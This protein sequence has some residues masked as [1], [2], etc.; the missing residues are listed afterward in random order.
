MTLRERST[1]RP[2]AG[3]LTTDRISYLIGAGYEVGFGVSFVLFQAE[4]T[5]SGLVR[6]GL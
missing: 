3:E 2:S 1:G 6:H 4:R 5:G